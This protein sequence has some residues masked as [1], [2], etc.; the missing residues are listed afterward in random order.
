MQIDTIIIIVL[1]I[2]ILILVVLF[3]PKTNNDTALV[4]LKIDSL[5]S[6]LKEDFILNRTEVAA[7]SKENRTE[8]NDTLKDLKEELTQTLS[9]SLKDFIAEQRT[10]FDEL[11]SGQKE[12]AA[13]TI[14]QLEKISYSV[15]RKLS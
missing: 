12:L 4:S 5:Q 6:G 7:I 2:I 13:A 9:A 14:E 1:L 3:N 11:R 10:K 15:E 8:L